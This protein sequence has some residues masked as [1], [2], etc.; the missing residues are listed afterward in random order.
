MPTASKQAEGVAAAGIHMARMR[1]SA[2]AKEMEAKMKAMSPQTHGH[3]HGVAGK[4]WQRATEA[5]YDPPR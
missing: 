3:G 1:R 5:V 2:Y 4:A